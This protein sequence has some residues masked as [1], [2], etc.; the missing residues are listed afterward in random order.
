MAGKAITA[1]SAISLIGIVLQSPFSMMFHTGT[2]AYLKSGSEKKPLKNFIVAFLAHSY[3]DG[4]LVYVDIITGLF[5]FS[6]LYGELLVWIPS[7]VIATAF[8]FYLRAY[9]SRSDSIK[10]H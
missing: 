2:A 3:V 10:I 1:I 5:G 6:L 4:M 9:L 8:L 7:M